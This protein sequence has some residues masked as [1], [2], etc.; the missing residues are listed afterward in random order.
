ML[1][2]S[3][4]KMGTIY[5]DVSL[6][7]SRFTSLFSRMGNNELLSSSDC[8]ILLELVILFSLSEPSPE[9][10]SESRE[11]RDGLEQ[12]LATDEVL[13]SLVMLPGLDVLATDEVLVSLVM[14]PGLDVL[15]TDEVLVS[16]VIV[17]RLDGLALDE[18]LVSTV[19]GPGLD[20]PRSQ[21]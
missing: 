5:L 8:S 14:V 18:V 16:L 21:S 1:G 4:I 7:C 12:L 20:G 15:A 9:S 10:H 13:V 11:Q 19:M 2:V 17:P 3:Q 6:S